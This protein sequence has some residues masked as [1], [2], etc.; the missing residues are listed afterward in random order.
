[1]FGDLCKLLYIVAW[2]KLQG[3]WPPPV[4]LRICLDR[5]STERTARIIVF[6]VTVTLLTCWGVH[7]GTKV[8]PRR[9]IAVAPGMLRR[10]FQN[11]LSF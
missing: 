10:V 6:G 3:S 9:N 1:M 4:L 8:T 11:S 7:I 2:S 5:I